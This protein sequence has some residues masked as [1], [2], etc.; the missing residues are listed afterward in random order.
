MTFATLGLVLSALEGAQVWSAAARK[1]SQDSLAV[2]VIN[3]T[4]TCSLASLSGP[5]LVTAA[6]GPLCYDGSAYGFLVRP[7]GASDLLLHF[8]HDGL[9]I[10]SAPP[11]GKAVEFCA[12]NS[13]QALNQSSGVANYISAGTVVEILGCS[14]D[15]HSGNSVTRASLPGEVPRELF[16]TGYLNAK[17]AVDWARRNMAGLRHLTIAGSAAGAWGACLW[18][19]TLLSSFEYESAALVV[20][21]LPHLA[22]PSALSYLYGTWG[23]CATPLGAVC[24]GGS[25]LRR[26]MLER[27][28]VAFGLVQSKEDRLSAGLCALVAQ[29]LQ[30]RGDCLSYPEAYRYLL[31]SVRL[32]NVAP[33]FVAFFLDGFWRAPLSDPAFYSTTFSAPLRERD[34][35][36]RPVDWLRG[37]VACEAKTVCVGEVVARPEL[38]ERNDTGYCDGALLGKM[39]VCNDVARASSPPSAPKAV[40]QRAALGS[41]LGLVLKVYSPD[42]EYIAYEIKGIVLVL[43]VLVAC[44]VVIAI[45]LARQC[46]RATAV[47]APWGE[48]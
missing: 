17:A 18:A 30:V 28:E 29:S 25:L 27:R 33:N 46:A 48:E 13:R 4:E 39:L 14:G 40:V 20:D 11:N 24:E 44:A 37:L 2:C 10:P 1:G 15:M 3:E 8:H 22:S 21:W 16:Q 12:R 41:L 26:V 47:R 7:G 36:I 9:C 32:L 34:E 31:Q 19:D 43:A 6:S 38:K 35:A 42:D 45:C 5:T 23:T